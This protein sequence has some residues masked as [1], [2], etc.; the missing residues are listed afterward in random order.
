MASGVGVNW[1]TSSSH[2]L[3]AA[4][5]VAGIL[6]PNNITLVKLAD[7]EPAVLEALSGSGVG[8][9]VGIPNG[10]LRALSSSKKAAASWVHDNVTRYFPALRIEHIAVGDEPFLL[11]YGLQFQP[12]V[13]GAAMNIQLGLVAAKLGNKIKVIVPCSSDVYQFNSMDNNSTGNR[14][15]AVLLPSMGSFRPE[16]NITMHELLSF[17]TKHGSPFVIDIDPFLSFQQNKNISKGYILF[18]SKSRQLTDGRNKYK[19]FFDASID[20][21]VT[22]LSKAG[23]GDMEIIVGRI[24]WPTDGAINATSSIARTFMQGLVDHL[25]SKSGTPQRPKKP[26]L[27]TYIFSL[28]DEDQRAITTGDFERHWG[29]FTFDGQAKYNLDLGQGSKLVNAR[30]VDYLASK[31]CVVNNNLDLSNVSASFRDACSNADCTALTPG[32]SCSGISWPGNVSYA[33]NSYY[34]QHD[35]RGDSCDFGGLGLITTV[36]PSVGECRFA[37]AVRT[38]SS[39]FVVAPALWWTIVMSVCSLLRLT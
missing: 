19:N 12:F 9:T 20:T 5:V 27:E 37:V 3:P 31:W 36:D 21:L 23:F 4:E 16:L 1:G 30:N 13:L 15:D 10:M 18:G 32:G 35:Q 29:I 2:P 6:R 11:S 22:S 7:A 33:Y 39:P 14:S 8:V 28:L 38:S 17:L 26:P 24:G 25:Q 34:Q